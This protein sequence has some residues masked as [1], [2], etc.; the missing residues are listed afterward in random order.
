MMPPVP[1]GTL[2]RATL[3]TCEPDVAGWIVHPAETGSAL[4]YVGVALLVWL[5]YR[6]ADRR[7]P[8]RFLPA[9]VCSIGAASLLFH[10]SFRAP[11]Q[12]LDLAVVSL[13]TGYVLAASLV[14]RRR[15]AP[16]VLPRMVLVFAA[17][18]VVASLLHLGLGFAT[19][20]PTERSRRCSVTAQ[21][22]A[23]L[24]M[25]QG[26]WLADVRRDARRATGLLFV[27]AALLGLD[28]AGIGCPGG[29][30]EHLVPPHAVPTTRTWHLLSAASVWYFYRTER[31]LER[32]W[33]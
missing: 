4:A 26:S 15:I 23:V 27:G 11:F 3:D 33:R 7:I 2:P 9:I 31:Q 12:T 21:A 6:R 24:W 17:G 1:W 30:V 20:R 25:W 5:R 14:H 10:A 32:R 8:A 18:G 29:G 13:F 16:P 28:H 22:A 19:W